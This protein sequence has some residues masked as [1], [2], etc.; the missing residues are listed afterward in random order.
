MPGGVVNP[1]QSKLCF[2]SVS[3]PYFRLDIQCQ[4]EIILTVFNEKFD[5]L[6]N[7]ENANLVFWMQIARQ[8][9]AKPNR[10]DICE[11]PKFYK[12]IFFFP[13][14]ADKKKKI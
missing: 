12:E 9:R 5:Y 10:A 3:R 7:K 11:V 6:F 4:F 14:F 13:P 8:R 2:I 1:V